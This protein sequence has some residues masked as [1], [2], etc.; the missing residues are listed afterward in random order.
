[1]ARRICF[2]IACSYWPASGWRKEPN[3]ARSRFLDFVDKANKPLRF[4]AATTFD[5]SNGQYKDFIDHKDL[6]AYLVDADEMITFNGRVYDLVVL[7]NLVGEE[8]AKAL[9]GKPHYDLAGWHIEWGLK[10]ATEYFLPDLASSFE[11]TFTER[12]AEL[13]APDADDRRLN[14]LAGTYRDVKFTYALFEKYLKSGDTDRPVYDL[15]S[16]MPLESL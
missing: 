1:M 8:P 13:G 2:D 3:E 11:S 10:R 9:W 5:D 15:E 6:F 7:E 16:L 4:W 14:D 12:R